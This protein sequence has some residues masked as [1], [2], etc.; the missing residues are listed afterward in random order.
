MG[1]LG[2]MVSLCCA[3]W[4]TRQ[5]VF[6]GGC[7]I[8]HLHKQSMWV[9]T[10]PQSPEYSNWPVFTF[11]YSTKCG[12]VFNCGTELYFLK[13]GWHWTYMDDY[14]CR[15]PHMSFG[16]VSFQIFCPFLKLS[17]FL[18]I[19]YSRL[20]V[21]LGYKFFIRQM[22]CKYFLLVC[23]LCS[24]YHNSA[25]WIAVVLNFREVQTTFSFTDCAFWSY[26]RNLCLPSS[27]KDF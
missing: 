15:H 9:H 14:I 22:V 25:F 16:E 26:L 13:N 7:T 6:Q 4:E 10:A 1:Q 12:A 11:S 19:E 20:S 3:L 18:T 23:D 27:H 24:C 21:Y 17:C 2:C 5:T 8:L